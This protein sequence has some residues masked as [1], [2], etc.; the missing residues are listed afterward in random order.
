[1]R[2]ARVPLLLALVGLMISIAAS[3]SSRAPPSLAIKNLR[4]FVDGT[5]FIVKGFNYQPTPLGY[6]NDT[7]L[8]SYRQTPW[9]NEVRRRL[10]GGDCADMPDP[11]CLL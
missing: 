3:A 2:R 7:G 4:L 1:M 9:Q 8:C 6:L 10:V 5:E 11:D